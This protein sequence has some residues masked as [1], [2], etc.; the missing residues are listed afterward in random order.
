MQV[1][2]LPTKGQRLSHLCAAQSP[3]S[4]S[5]TTETALLEN[6]ARPTPP[7]FQF[8]AIIQELL[9]LQDRKWERGQQERVQTAHLI[10]V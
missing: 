7:H 9:S 5:L 3:C 4:E 2:A 6:F 1:A 10:M 8:K